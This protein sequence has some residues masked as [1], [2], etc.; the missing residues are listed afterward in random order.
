[1]TPQPARRAN[2]RWMLPLFMLIL[3]ALACQ[4]GPYYD[5]PHVSQVEADSKMP[6][7]AFARVVSSTIPLDAVYVTVDY[8]Q[9][10]RPRATHTFS[11]APP[12]VLNINAYG[13]TLYLNNQAIWSFPRP[14]FR[15][16][17]SESSCGTNSCQF[18]LFYDG[19]TVSAALQGDWLYVA[20][21]TEGVLVGRLKDGTLTDWQ[22]TANGIDKLS[23]DKLTVTDPTRLLEFTAAALLVPPYP[24]IHGLLLYWLWMYVLPREKAKLYAIFTSLG[25]TILGAIATGI[26][27]TDVRTDFYSVVG[28]ISVIV[29]LI[30]V[31]LTLW[32]ARGKTNVPKKRWLIVA[33]AL[34]S[35]IVPAG[36]I[37][38][39]AGWWVVYLLV[40]G[41]WV[42]HRIFWNTIQPK[43]DDWRMRWLVD[44]LTI[45]TLVVA[46]IMMAVFIM[47]FVTLQRGSS[48]R[49]A[50]LSVVISLVIA[51]VLLPRYAKYRLRQVYKANGEDLQHCNLAIRG[52]MISW[53]AVSVWV[54]LVTAV[55]QFVVHVLLVG[56]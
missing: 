21:G 1:M 39:Y 37:A 33:A 47:T 24:I 22:V 50:D 34:V 19:D 20:M 6:G 44:R 14:T 48:E 11:S 51:F 9:H 7:H 2:W 3:S 49:A 17:I 31:I 32:F 10:W 56:F 46:G 4:P 27:L 42:F 38:I 12:A 25:L 54:T 23:P 28:A 43:E 41:Y 30:G 16:L 53:L 5:Y 15:S 55:A 45:E 36:V 26:W 35:A 13:E 40:L 18:K 52:E 8:G 29:I